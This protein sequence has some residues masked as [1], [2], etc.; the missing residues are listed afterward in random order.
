MDLEMAFMNTPGVR[1]CATVSLVTSIFTSASLSRAPPGPHHQH[2][3]RRARDEPDFAHVPL[4]VFEQRG[5]TPR[6]AVR[7]GAIVCMKS[8]NGI[9]KSRRLRERS[10]R[11]GQRS[12]SL[13]AKRFDK[14]AG[15]LVCAVVDLDNRGDNRGLAGT[16]LPALGSGVPRR[17][18][19]RPGFRS[20]TNVPRPQVCCSRCRATFHSRA[21]AA[22][23]L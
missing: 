18:A 20:G 3:R 17:R 21:K 9:D 4:L 5:D 22:T 10:A 6:G 8:G 23:R 1:P 16:N 13:K 7:L 19:E 15:R 12:L 11:G 2:R 14:E